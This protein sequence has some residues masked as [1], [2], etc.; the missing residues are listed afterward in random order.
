MLTVVP[1]EIRENA[2]RAKGYLRREEIVRAM[3]NMA[4]ALRGYSGLQFARAAR[5]EMEVNFSEFLQEL[6]RHPTMRSLLDVNGTGNP[7]AINYQRGKEA[8]LA[9]VFEGLIKIMHQAEEEKERQQKENNEARLKELIATGLASI[10]SGEHAKGR[11]FLKR[12]ASEFGEDYNVLMDIGQKFISVECHLEAAEVFEMAM[13][14]DPKRPEG[15][16]AAIDAY[17]CINEMEKAEAVY[18]KILRQF[19]GHA[20][21]YG[22]MALMYLTWHKRMKAEEFANRALQIDREEESALQVYERLNLRR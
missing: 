7:R 6:C 17:E 16:S 11:A 5:F 19:G 20:K 21:T 18:K 10:E 8:I 4:L 15:Y 13:E 22:R 1:R 9:A 14:R 12:A 3:E 2:A